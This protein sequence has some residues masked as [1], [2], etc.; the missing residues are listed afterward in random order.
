ML[1]F[2][3]MRFRDQNYTVSKICCFQNLFAFSNLEIKEDDFAL[4]DFKINVK[5]KDQ[6]TSELFK[7]TLKFQ[8][9]ILEKDTKVKKIAPANIEDLTGQ[10]GYI[11]KLSEKINLKSLMHAYKNFFLYD[12]ENIIK[13][14]FA[15]ELQK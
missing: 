9:L 11:K 15:T 3:R 2:F 8:Y 1:Q 13:P 4:P 6:L 10:S 12:L 7:E 14:N 5:L